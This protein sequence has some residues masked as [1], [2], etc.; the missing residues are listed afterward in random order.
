MKFEIWVFFENLSKIQVSLNS[1]K[2]NGYQYTFLIIPRSLLLRMRNF[3]HK[4]CRE[5]QNTRFIFNNAFFSPRKSHCLWDNVEKY[6]ATGKATNHNTTRRMGF[7]SWISKAR[8]T[9]S[10]YAILN[11]LKTE[12]NPVCHLL[13]LLGTHPILHVSRIRV[14]PF[15]RQ[16]WCCQ[17]LSVTF[18]HTLLCC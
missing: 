8:D 7:A 18:L 5:N 11:T 10:E 16:Q 2:N 6:G 13:A 1:D 14:N 4:C 15:Q 9:H 3:S 17:R 12:L